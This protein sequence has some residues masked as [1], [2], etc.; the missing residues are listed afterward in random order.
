MA[1]V[2]T[3][4][5][6]HVLLEAGSVL[7]FESQSKPTAL[8]DGLDVA[9]SEDERPNIA[10]TLEVGSPTSP[11]KH[12]GVL[13]FSYGEEMIFNRI[14][15]DP[16]VINP[17]FVSEDVTYEVETWN[18][19]IGKAVDWTAEA[20][21]GD[22]E[23]V[24]YDRDPLT[25][26]I[27]KFDD[28]VYDMVLYREGP[29]VQDTLYTETIDGDDYTIDID[30][31]RVVAL[32]PEPDWRA[33]VRI[34]YRFKTAMAQNE[35]L[36]E[37]RRPLSHTVER[38]LQVDMVV[39][40]NIATKVANLLRYGHDKVFACPIYPERML[41]T[42]LTQG[43]TAVVL[44]TATTKMWNLNNQCTRI[45]IVDHAAGT[46]EVKTIDSVAAN[47]INTTSEI[48]GS[49]TPATSTVYPVF[50]GVAKAPKL[51]HETDTVARIGLSFEEYVG[52]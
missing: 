25:I 22:T 19:Y 14:W 38:T 46:T 6:E 16:P 33:K 29:A 11:I 9:A 39:D 12:D 52:G 10:A 1:Y 15:I 5:E 35:R 47:Q 43:T 50:L 36:H 3:P 2:G 20:V 31:L 30:T 24:L 40:G 28:V 41:P 7:T 17:A 8:R 13:A 27:D 51:K 49:F 23:G 18:A 4:I 45:L 48:Q 34:G 44:S 42:T 32:S 37:Q 21:T 26:T